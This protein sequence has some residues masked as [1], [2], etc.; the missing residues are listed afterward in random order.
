M[1]ISCIILGIIIY[2]MRNSYKPVGEHFLEQRE[3]EVYTSDY[4]QDD[5]VLNFSTYPQYVP[6]PP[7]YLINFE[8]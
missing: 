1:L 7:E 2:M 8:D 3:Y 6:D 5:V 4:P